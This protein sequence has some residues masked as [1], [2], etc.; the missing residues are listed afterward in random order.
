MPPPRTTNSLL[1]GA[2]KPLRS[3]PTYT[4]AIGA[5]PGARTSA[6][7]SALTPSSGSTCVPQAA[8]ETALKPSSP[9][10]EGAGNPDVTVV[11]V[12]PGGEGKSTLGNLLV[13]GIGACLLGDPEGSL[14][15]TSL[16]S[17]DSSGVEAAHAD[18]VW[19]AVA[20]RVID[21]T[22]LLDGLSDTAERISRLAERA[23]SGIDVFLF[24]VRKGRF[25]EELFDQFC[26]FASAVG[27]TALKRTVLVFT[28]CARETNDQLRERCRKTPNGLLRDALTKTAGVVGID[29]LAPGRHA[30]D[31]AT[32]LA[33][34]DEVVQS[35][36]NLPKTRPTNPAELRRSLFELNR[37]MDGLSDE[38]RAAMQV[39]L[40][41]LNSGRAS[42]EALRKAMSEARDRQVVEE[43]SNE[44]HANLKDS[45]DRAQGEANA[46]KNATKSMITRAERRS[47]LGPAWACCVPHSAITKACEPCSGCQDPC[48]PCDSH[49]ATW[50]EGIHEQRRQEI[51]SNFPTHN[52]GRGLMPGT[53]VHIEHIR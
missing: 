10:G 50:A 15:F 38:R 13:R 45:V 11:L 18:F 20:H 26:S 3:S 29:C 31:R 46:F 48:V 53:A 37:E 44:E 4:P 49:V 32:V 22:G 36:G 39:K 43:A 1:G 28:H 8:P 42:L 47:E 27:G 33:A 25:T 12:G 7:Q 24:V 16:E 9:S 51:V 40:D 21:T 6:L 17:F 23:P 34:T 30:E 19:N 5:A 14:P 35:H 2:L 52:P 41:A